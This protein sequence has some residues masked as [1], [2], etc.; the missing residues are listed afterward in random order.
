MGVNP[1]L[2][3]GRGIAVERRRNNSLSGNVLIS[4]NT[5]RNGNGQNEG[6]LTH[7]HIF[8]RTKANSNMSVTVTNNNVDSNFIARP[9][10]ASTR[11]PTRLATSLTPPNATDITGNTFAAGGVIDINEILGTHNVEQASAAAVA[12][13]NG[14]VTVNADPGVAFGVPCAVPPALADPLDSIDDN[15]CDG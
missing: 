2:A 15:P 8:A 14:G 4:N 13:A 6:A 11:T 1:G 7:A 3:N 5:V 10:C 9:K 12:A